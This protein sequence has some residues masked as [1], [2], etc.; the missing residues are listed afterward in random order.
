MAN[1]EPSK[2]E[3]ERAAPQ[4]ARD[5]SKKKLV[6]SSPKVG[7][8]PELLTYRCDQCGEVETIEAR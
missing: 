2:I 3:P 6:R 1:E 4:C 7:S 8:F 5:G